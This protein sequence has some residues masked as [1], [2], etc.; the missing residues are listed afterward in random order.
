MGSGF[1]EP[2]EDIRVLIFMTV[3]ITVRFASLASHGIG[4][5]AQA[6]TIF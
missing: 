3:S 2:T 5:F 6:E 1:V 4:Y